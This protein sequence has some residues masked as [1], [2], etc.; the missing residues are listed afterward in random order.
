MADGEFSDH[1]ITSIEQLEGPYGAPS[2]PSLVK[3]IDHINTHYRAF[4]EAA[5][6]VAIA[7]CGPE[8]LDCSPRGDAPGF[9]RLHDERTLL[10]PDRPG[11]NRT[12]SLRNILRDPRV[13]LLFLV[14][15]AGETFRV[16]GRA[17]ISI[18][19][20]LRESFAVNGK[21]ARAVI[22]VTVERAYF[23]CSKAI[24]R[25]KL[26]DPT[27]HVDRSSLPSAGQI[28]TEISKGRVDGAKLDREREE[29]IKATLY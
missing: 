14:P 15:G 26:W 13:A 21:P 17:Q 4:I 12:D 3:E 20:G 29:R 27:R 11:N 28:I 1:L 25:S 22:I 23:Q 24:V 9:V 7:T 2:E 19:P 10:I 5:P 18:D 6:F 8:G 16:N